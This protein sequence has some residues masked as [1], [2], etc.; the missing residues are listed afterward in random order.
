M[1]DIGAGGG[2]RPRAARA[3]A[4]SPERRRLRPST[5]GPLFDEYV[6]GAGLGERLRFD[7]GDFFA[8][9]L[10]EA[11]VLIMGHILHDWDLDEKRLLLEKAH[12]ALPDGG[13]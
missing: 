5:V 13:A 3:G 10:P 11:D 6:G 7:P 2:L 8:D 1:I 9:D 4:R 12:A